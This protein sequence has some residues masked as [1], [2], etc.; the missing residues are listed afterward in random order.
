MRR[1]SASVLC[2]ALLGSIIILS[3]ITCVS[4]GN[5]RD[6]EEVVL[7]IGVMDK[8]D[9]LN[10]MIQLTDSSRMLSGFFYD[11]LMAVGEDM[12]PVPN[13]ATEW[14][15]V[16]DSD[17]E[18]ILS[19]EQYGSVWEYDLTANA[20][21]HDGEQ[22][23]ADDVEFSFDLYSER[24]DIIWAYSPYSRFMSYADALDDYTVRVHF[25]DNLT[26]EPMP[27][28]FGDS[29]Y[30]PI[31]P[32]HKFVGMSAFDISFTWTG[33]FESADPPLVGTGPFVAPP[34]L[35]DDWLA[36][37]KISVIRNPDYH[38]SVEYGSKVLVDRIDIVFFED[39]ANISSALENGTIDVAC[40]SEEAFVSL[41]GDPA[42]TEDEAIALGSYLGPNG[43]IRVI[44]FTMTGSFDSDICVD[45]A[46]RRA[47][48]HATDRAKIVEVC[49][50]GLGEEGS[51]LLSPVMGDWHYAPATDEEVVF[52]V[53]LANELLDEAGYPYSEEEGLRVTGPDCMVVTEGL[54]PEG[55]P[56]VFSMF[57][58]IEHK[59]IALA[60][61]DMY[62]ELSILVYPVVAAEDRWEL[63]Y[64]PYGYPFGIF[65][66][67]YY[68]SPSSVLFTQSMRALDTWSDN[69]Y[70][71]AE[72]DDNFNI[73]I[74]ALDEEYR[75]DAT[76]ECQRIHH[77]DI[78]YI[79]L[80]YPHDLYAWRT[81]RFE[82]ISECIECP[83]SGLGN[84]WGGAAF[85]QGLS[86][87]ASGDD[88]NGSVLNDPVLW[89][90]V[91][92]VAVA[93]VAAFLLVRRHGKF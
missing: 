5:A 17:P 56:L 88:G 85:V 57:V 26:G 38:W 67:S 40:L 28:S 27:C 13:L 52:D 15:I 92:I 68:P 73:S 55:T 30:I 50:S 61:V 51:T 14:R 32:E 65:D 18:L 90:G 58:P 3:S 19:G 54:E 46:V 91:V 70:S 86:V 22:F 74:T 25:Y 16:P 8:V 36:Q 9:T 89:G 4:G 47:F 80:A 71:N 81:D 37:E 79:V 72:Y 78:A 42:V 34:S 60:L 43:R 31:L 64:C 20:S 66:L 35:Y 12:E 82:G 23:T 48:A 45:P 41:Q 29:L 77:E 44:S 33:M 7:R 69:K 63:V 11:G 87:T 21:W 62:A 75:M 76:L 10:P 59:E 2:A 39:A 1:R 6:S 84:V 24:P 83:W 49:M 53:A 93:G